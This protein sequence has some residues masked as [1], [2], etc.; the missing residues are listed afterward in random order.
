MERGLTPAQSRAVRQIPPKDLLQF[1]KIPRKEP[2]LVFSWTLILTV[3][4]RLI[5]PSLAC[6]Q[7]LFFGRNSWLSRACYVCLQRKGLRKTSRIGVLRS[8]SVFPVTESPRQT[9]VG[10][11]W[12]M[13]SVGF[14]HGCIKGLKQCH[15]RL[16]F[17]ASLYSTC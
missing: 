2:K 8:D 14:R 17:S 1:Y 15:Q 16:R 10:I 9:I 7:D 5:D 11:N 4:L 3:H 12:L 6:L 13:F